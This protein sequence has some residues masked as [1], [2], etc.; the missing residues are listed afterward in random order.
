MPR[1]IVAGHGVEEIL[2]PV[3]ATCQQPCQ[4]AQ[5]QPKQGEP[6]QHRKGQV[7][8]FD[9]REGRDDE[10]EGRDVER[11]QDAEECAADI[12]RRHAGEC[13]AEEAQGG[14][15]RQHQLDREDDAAD[16]RV[17]RGGDAAAGAGGNQQ[18]PL[19]DGHGDHLAER[20]AEGCTDLD[21]RSLAS[22][23]AAASDRKG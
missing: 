19:P 14:C 10:R 11:R 15:E 3:D 6:R 21:D 1:V 23:R 9:E 4:H 12:G 2:E 16:R 13:D 7:R 5:N 18:G 20:R 8:A 17:K 22:N